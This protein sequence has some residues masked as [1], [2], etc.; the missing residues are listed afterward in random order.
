MIPQPYP[1]TFDI[2]PCFTF[3]S[4]QKTLYLLIIVKIVKLIKNK[5]YK[6]YKMHLKEKVK[7]LKKKQAEEIEITL[8]LTFLQEE[9][10]LYDKGNR[11]S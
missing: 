2:L 9:K 6:V 7:R 4:N 1:F 10:V 11:K 8:S 3:L 5:K